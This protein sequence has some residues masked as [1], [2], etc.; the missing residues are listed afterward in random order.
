MGGWADFEIASPVL[1]T[2]TTPETLSEASGCPCKAL[3]RARRCEDS[4]QPTA[5]P[6]GPGNEQPHHG[7]GNHSQRPRKKNR[8]PSPLAPAQS[9]NNPAHTC[10]RP[11]STPHTCN[12]GAH[13]ATTCNHRACPAHHLPAPS[14]HQR[15]APPPHHC[16]PHAHPPPPA[17]SGQNEGGPWGTLTSAL[18][19]EP[20]TSHNPKTGSPCLP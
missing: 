8:Y 14:H 19:R 11:A 20:I 9:A 16:T 13:L 15:T 1:P 17:S 12:Q 3:A 7:N 2:L 5:G 4:Q 18:Q 10:P 6:A